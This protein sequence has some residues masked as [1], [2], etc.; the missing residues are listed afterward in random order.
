MP[1]QRVW[2][3]DLR[4]EVPVEKSW[5][6]HQT[7]VQ[8]FSNEEKKR[9]VGE[10]LSWLR[11]RPAFSR[12]LNAVHTSLYSILE[13]ENPPM[14]EQL[15]QHLEEVVVQVDSYLAPTSAQLIFLTSAPMPANCRDWLEQWWDGASRSAAASELTLHALD[16]RTLESVSVLEYRRMSRIW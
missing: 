10:R 13:S 5:L 16:F 7:R 8:A 11:G 15:I 3:A 9:K 4:I 2:V 14:D 6:A 1:D 12:A